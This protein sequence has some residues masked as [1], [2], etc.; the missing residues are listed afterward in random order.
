MLIGTA[1]KADPDLILRGMRAGRAGVSRL[2]A[3]SERPRRRARPARSARDER[4]AARSRGRGLQRKGRSRHDERRDQPRVWLREESPDRARR[5]RRLRDGRR[6]RARVPE[7]RSRRTTSATWSSKMDR[8]DEELLLSVLSA[9]DR[10]RV[11]AAGVRERGSVRDARRDGVGVDPQPPAGALLVVIDCEHHMSDRTLAAFDAADRIV[12]V[13]QLTIPALGSTKRTLELCERL[14]YPESKIFVVVNRHHSGDVLSPWVT[15]R[16]CSGERSSGDPERLSRFRRRT[17]ARASRSSTRTLD[18][19]R[20]NRS[21]SS[22]RNSVVRRKHLTRT[23][24]APTRADRASADSCAWGERA[25]WQ[26]FASDSWVAIS[27]SPRSQARAA[28]PA[29][30]PRARHKVVR[31]APRRPDP[32]S[33]VGADRSNPYR[34][35]HGRNHRRHHVLEH[36]SNVSHDAADLAHRSD[37]RPHDG[38]ST[39]GSQAR[40]ARL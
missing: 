1:P 6:R 23:A 9:T 16:K 36:A 22:R 33:A 17:H 40:D 29:R 19:A 30:L 35:D 21:Y 38:S 14:G 2:A 5:A 13:T 11:G 7:S 12:L 28:S 3:G 4:D 15:P 8:I 39:F 18:A 25:K 31:Q 10:R 26:V 20:R 32:G 37:D 34:P 24:T 27:L